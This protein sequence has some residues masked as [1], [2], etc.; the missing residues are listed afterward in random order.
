MKV[1]S[2]GFINWDIILETAEIPQEDMSSEINAEYKKPGGSATNTALTLNS[3]GVNSVLTGSIGTD[4]AAT[5]IKNIL[6]TQNLS[7]YVQENE[8][9]SK[10]YSLITDSKDP[11]YLYTEDS[12]GQFST[13]I[14]PED[15]WNTITH[16]HITSFD[17]TI[18][19][20]FVKKASENNISI[21]FNPNHKFT[22]IE[23]PFIVEHSDVI[24]LN[25][26]EHKTLSDRYNMSSLTENT[27][28]VITHGSNGCSA[29][30]ND[31]KT[32]H[33]G[34]EADVVDTVGAGDS[35]ISGFLTQWLNGAKLYTCL[36]YG[37]AVAATSVQTRGSPNNIDKETLKNFL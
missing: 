26:T 19:N 37:N 27:T 24:I 17:K 30:E 23:F 32:T 35:F 21:S 8:N 15:V 3:L 12:I 9:T 28:V 16:L 1:L 13:D 2:A 22:N 6:D 25:D 31:S 7:Y 29:Y 4:N 34:F 33:S 36:K 10:I 20:K 11:R 14:V 18:S 5:K